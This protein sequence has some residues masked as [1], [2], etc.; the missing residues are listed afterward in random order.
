M[1]YLNRPVYYLQV[2]DF[3]NEGNLINPQIPK[4]IPV[5]IMIQAQF[6]HY[7]SQA[8]PA[9]QKFA[10]NMEGK[11]FA[12]TIQPDGEEPGEKELMNLIEKI[13]PGFVGFPDYV[14]YIG[15]KR[16]GKNIKGRGEEHLIE[17][18]S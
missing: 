17:F 5:V 1:K 4:D 9:F 18:V 10:N 2:S 15:G 14:L 12:A 6:C 7:C 11:V 8:K 3:D 16:V 13:K